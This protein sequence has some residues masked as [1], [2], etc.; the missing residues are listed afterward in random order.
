M[1]GFADYARYDGR[2]LAE[3]VRKK[4]VKPS[5]LVEEAISRIEKL[6][7]QLNAVVYKMC[8]LARQSACGDLPDG[9]FKGVPFLMKDWL[10]AFAGAPLTNGN[11]FFR[12]SILDYDSELVKRFKAC[13]IIVI[14]KTNT[15]EFGMAPVTEP[16]LLALPTTHG[17]WPVLQVVPVVARLL[18]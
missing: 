8:K 14:G 16:E 9:P 12:D 1:S 5:E 6:N 4:E 15:P 11:R 10:V 7:P 2:G 18:L 17:V 13:G 3:L